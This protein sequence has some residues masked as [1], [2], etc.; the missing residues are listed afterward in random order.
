MDWTATDS[1][2]VTGD[3]VQMDAIEA[4]RHYQPEVIVV[5]W[6]PYGSDLD[7]RL[8]EL[9]GELG[10]PLILIGEGH[11][12]CTGSNEFW[13]RGREVYWDEDTDEEI[14]NESL[15]WHIHAVCSLFDWFS[16]VPVWSGIHDYTSIVMPAGVTF[17][18]EG[19]GV[20][21]PPV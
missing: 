10:I 21:G 4:V 7:A 17:V 1:E 3:V 12:G 6:V 20:F 11:G 15:D 19:Q 13:N 2:P 8:A 5:S 18:V 14:E 16:D 9:A